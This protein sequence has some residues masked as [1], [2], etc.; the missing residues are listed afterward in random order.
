MIENP[1]RGPR[2]ILADV[3]RLAIEYYAV[4]GR[5]L[6]VTGELAEFEASEKLGLE[7]AIVRTEGFDAT[8][9]VNGRTMQVQIK[10]RRITRGSLYRGS[11]PQI[12]LC[13]PFDTVMLVLMNKDYDAVEIWEAPRDRVE[14]RLTAPGS[15]AR[16]ERG[17]MSISQF[18]SIAER[19]WRS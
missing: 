1:Q 10:G 15:K 7:L 8:K 17:A 12:N 2:D 3:K 14:A 11:V 5:P 16:N 19:V 18:K 6:G 4:T 9:V 13:K